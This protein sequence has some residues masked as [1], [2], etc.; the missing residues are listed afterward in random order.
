M[1]NDECVLQ[2]AVHFRNNV[3]HTIR[4]N[5]CQAEV[6]VHVAVFHSSEPSGLVSQLLLKGYQVGLAYC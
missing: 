3:S 2:V 1:V 6:H 4:A 5:L